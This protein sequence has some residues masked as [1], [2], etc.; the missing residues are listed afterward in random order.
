MIDLSSPIS[1]K[2]SFLFPLQNSASRR[3]ILIGGLLLLIPILGWLLNL[4]H[5]IVIVH[6]MQHD[7][8][9]WPSWNNWPELL[10]HG[11]ITWLGMVYYYS[12]AVILFLLGY[13]LNND[14][15]YVLSFIF[16]L[17]A[18]IAIPGYMTHYCLN[19]DCQEIFN[20]YKALRRIIQGGKGYWKAWSIALLALFISL[21]GFL[22]FG[23]GFLF[24]S[25]W[26]WQVAGYSFAVTFT[27]VYKL[28][29]S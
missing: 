23:I 14:W 1:L 6:K 3:E 22:I 19:Y 4:G 17:L 20:P 16:S 5:R 21:F 13:S 10:K 12:P 26:F 29:Q 27:H 7:I 24:T 18:T 11:F 25:V 9:P 2:N 15:L 28:Q 8:N